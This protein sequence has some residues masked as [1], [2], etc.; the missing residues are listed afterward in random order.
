[1]SSAE[2]GKAFGP[3]AQATAIRAYADRERLEIVADFLEDASGTLP[4]EERPQLA[5]ALAA[6]YQYG[7]GALLVARRDRLARDEYAAHDAIRAFKAAGVRVLYADG[8]NGNDDSALL[9]DGI[10][11]VIAAHERRAIVARLK[12]GR[13]AK[14]ARY[15]GSR[16]QGGR[17]P[18]GYRRSRDGIQ[19]EIDPEQ[20]TEVQRMYAL[21]RAGKSIRQIA[22]EV[23]RQ[24][25]A[26]ERILRR[27]DYKRGQSK[28]IDPRLW[29]ATQAALASRRKRPA[30][31]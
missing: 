17:V 12:A 20:A 14:A 23:G 8:A 22:A 11:H 15:P 18:F 21:A 16:P 4:L 13:D 24:P 26:V 10:Q 2:Q 5:A 19:I 29:N 7:A 25:T 9:L 1:V 27:E 28:I 31:R 3:D 6:T 30:A